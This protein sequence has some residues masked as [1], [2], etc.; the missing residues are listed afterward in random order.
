MTDPPT[1]PDATVVASPSAPGERPYAGRLLRVVRE[2]LLHF[3]LLG[4]ALFIVFAWRQREEAPSDEQIV[5]SAGKIEHLASLFARTW[6]RPPSA[7]ELKGLVDD[8]VREEV[9]YRE[10][11]ALG[12]DRDDTIIR[13]RIRQKLDFVAEDLASQLEPTDEELAA[14]LS[15]HAEQFQVAPRFSFRHV[16]FNPERHGEGLEA[17][18]ADLVT[19]LREDPAVDAR[20]QGDRTLLEFQYEDLSLREVDGL[21]GEP[22][23]VALNEVEPGQWEGPVESAYGVHAVI[24]D[25]FQPGRPQQLSEVREAVRR[26]WEHAR[27]EQLTEQFYQGLLDKYDVLIEWPEPPAEET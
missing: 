4:A 12:L 16:F 13:R 3:L 11:I 14:Y 10:G 21:F 17:D 5:V 23:A 7:V 20:M 9:A 1:A 15:S 6:Q 25:G 27:R 24:V 8:F 2:P 22:F 19:R 18:V 26:E